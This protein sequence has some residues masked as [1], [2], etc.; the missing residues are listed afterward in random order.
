MDKTA[1]K[2]LFGTRSANTVILVNKE[3]N[4]YHSITLLKIAGTDRLT[5]VL[6]KNN[7]IKPTGRI[8]PSL[9][10]SSIITAN[11]AI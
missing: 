2:G 6:I 7:H 3:H 1:Q 10:E 8:R 5:R 4:W 11:E 9:D